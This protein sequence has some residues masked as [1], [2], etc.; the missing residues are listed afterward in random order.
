LLALL[1]A[2]AAGHAANITYNLNVAVGAGS[3]A[4]TIVTDGT[5]GPLTLAN[6]VDWNLDIG[7]GTDP[8]VDLT[9]ANS[10]FAW[11]GFPGLHATGTQLIFDFFGP[12]AYQLSGAGYYMTFEG[13]IPWFSNALPGGWSVYDSAGSAGLQYT[14][15]TNAPEPSTAAIFC[16]GAAALALLRRRGPSA[17]SR[18]RF[19]VRCTPDTEPRP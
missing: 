5:I 17:R 10:T 6:F 3:V 18:S 13:G 7:D 11:D 4:G 12:G 19:G 1:G 2:A 9:G 14:S 15:E 16:C 8:S